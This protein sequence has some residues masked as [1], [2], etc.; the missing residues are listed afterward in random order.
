MPSVLGVRGEH[1]ESITV[2]S[3]LQDL[4]RS[5]GEFKLCN[6]FVIHR[7]VEGGETAKRS[8][9][10]QIGAFGRYGSPSLAKLWFY[11]RL[12]GAFPD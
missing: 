2:L 4:I 7:K 3:N 11:D 6:R 9:A 10:T 1:I 12:A 8:R 5:P